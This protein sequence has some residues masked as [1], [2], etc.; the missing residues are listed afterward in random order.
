MTTTTTTTVA[1][2]AQQ[3]GGFLP[4]VAARRTLFAQTVVT[5]A[6]GSTERTP[7]ANVRAADDLDVRWSPITP[8]RITET[9][10]VHLGDTPGECYGW[11]C[12]ACQ[13]VTGLEHGSHHSAADSLARHLIKRCEA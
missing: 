11:E 4:V 10:V 1:W 12:A 3:G 7:N 8:A 2:V 13:T 5:Y 6:D 9:T